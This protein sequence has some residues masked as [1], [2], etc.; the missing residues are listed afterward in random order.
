[1]H[2]ARSLPSR[3]DLLCNDDQLGWALAM[4]DGRSHQLDS[5]DCWLA[6]NP[7]PSFKAQMRNYRPRRRSTVADRCAINGQTSRAGGS[8]NVAGGGKGVDRGEIKFVAE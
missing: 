8:W 7:T 1:M 6:M 5:R 2:M 3:V 4:G